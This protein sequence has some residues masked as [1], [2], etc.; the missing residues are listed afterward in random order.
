GRREGH[1]PV[2]WGRRPPAAARQEGAGSPARA[3]S[4]RTDDG[5]DPGTWVVGRQQE[6]P[7]LWGFDGTRGRKGA[8]WAL[9]KVIGIRT[10]ATSAEFFRR[11]WREK[12][13]PGPG[14]SALG[15]GARLTR[16]VP[17]TAIPRPLACPAAARPGPGA[18]GPARNRTPP[19]RPP[20]ACLPGRSTTAATRPLAPR[21]HTG[22]APQR[23]SSSA[24]PQ[25]R[26]PPW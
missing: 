10:G 5:R 21:R 2:R 25:A 12:A 11:T 26:A 6:R 7:L 4:A 17:R 13:H 16:P 24:A 18:V 20:P 14:P 15:P 23:P 3:G 19:A 22:N 1:R 9:S 8:A